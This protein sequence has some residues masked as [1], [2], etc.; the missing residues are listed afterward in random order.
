MTFGDISF[1]KIVIDKTNLTYIWPDAFAASFAVTKELIISSNPHLEQDNMYELMRKFTNVVTIAE[2]HNTKMTMVP[3]NAFGNQPKIRQLTIQSGEQSIGSHAFR[4]LSSLI[5]LHIQWNSLS[6]FSA[7]AFSID[8]PSSEELYIQFDGNNFNEHS[9]D[10]GAYVGINRPTGLGS[11]WIKQN[12]LFDK[13]RKVK[14]SDELK[15]AVCLLANIQLIAGKCP[16]PSEILPCYGCE[17][18][19]ITCSG[20]ENIDLIKIFDKLNKAL[21]PKEKNFLTFEFNNTGVTHIKSNTFGDISF[22]K[23]LINHTNL[24]YI[25]PAA[26]SASHTVT[27]ELIIT[28]NPHLEHD[29]YELISIFTNVVNVVEMYN[30]KITMVPDNAFGNQPKILMTF[31]SL[32]ASISTIMSCFICGLVSTKS[33]K[34]QRILHAINARDLSDDEYNEWLMFGTI[35]RNTRTFG[36]TIGGYAVFNKLTFIE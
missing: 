11:Y 29:I 32:S 17:D 8:Q 10:T 18:G 1:G 15:W 3:E 25:N 5:G 4:G 9:F 27:K 28:S 26:F 23:I 36:F 7:N 22:A 6:H 33:A 20:N 19:F 14:C 34:L 21:D 12:N 30:T 35:V 16:D 24:V 31:N 13:F 2:L